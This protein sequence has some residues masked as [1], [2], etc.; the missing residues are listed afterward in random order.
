MAGLGWLRPTGLLALALSCPCAWGAASPMT[1]FHETVEPILKEYCYDCHGDGMNKG[2][3]AFDEFKSDDE[4]L[5]RRDLW[6]AVLKNVRAGLMPPEK[7]PRPSAEQ[8]RALADWIKRDAFGLDPQNPDPGRV[9]IRR[10]NRVEYRTTIRDLM[11]FD[12]K[13]EDELPPDDTGYGFDNIGDVLTISPMLLEKYMRAAETITAEAVP[14]VTRV[15]AEKTIPGSAFRKSEGKGSGERLTFYE[16]AKVGHTFKAE[17]AGNYRV[18]LELEVLGQFDFDPGKCRVV[19]RAGDRELVQKEFGWQ[20]G[21]KFKFDFD[22]SWDAGEHRLTLE[23]IPLLPVERKK[24]SLDLRLTAVKVQGPLAERHWVRPKNFDLFFAKDPPSSS[25]ARHN[26]AREVLARF[27]R[28]AYRRPADERTVNRLV[29]IAEGVC[30]QPGKRF[31]DGIAQAMVPVLASPR[32]LFRVEETQPS[33]AGKMHPFV[34]EYALASRLSYFLWS[35]MPDDELCRLAD[36]GELRKN[37]DAQVKRMLASRHSQ[38]LVQNFVGQWLQVRDVEGIDINAFVVLARDRGEEKDVERRRRRFQELN[39]IADE[40]RTPEEKAELQQMFE[41]RRRRQNNRQNVELDNELRRALREETEMCFAGVMREDRSV[42]ELI[43]S[44][45]TFL[46]ERLAKHYGLTNLN[47]TGPEM[48]RVSLPA[49]SPR[50]GVLTQGAMLI[51]TS[52]PTRTSPVKRGLFILDN[53]LGTPTPPPPAGVP[54]LEESEKEF[55]DRQPTLRETLDVHRGKPLCSSCHNRMDPLG[56]A[57][58]NFNALGM[59][60]EQERNQPIDATG[61]LITGEPFRDI[62]DV[63]HVVA[64]TRRLDFYRCLTEKLLTYALGRGLEFYDVETVDRIVERL[65]RA[66]GRFAELLLGIVESAPF[67]KRRILSA[68][69]GPEPPKPPEQRAEIKALP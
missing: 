54:Q 4:L 44:D 53:I 62:R 18:A 63:K 52:N 30:R 15:V 11:G 29:A 37:L 20:N 66:N 2:K 26:Y 22:Q 23:L 17:H 24:N 64:T 45:Y 14:R 55:K 25:V 7:K 43:E 33:S 39:A 6:F 19:F 5:A 10:L 35:T 38:A 65:D 31:A 60:R 57:L 58:E 40:K 46:N 56:L 3:V 16:A 67:Q 51:V 68:P 48:R 42:L 49:E 21:K 50:G 13:V 12:F 32:F 8:T 9:T 61:K 69:D 28:K 34:D 59:W 47:V 41:Q 36:R 27:T 1:R